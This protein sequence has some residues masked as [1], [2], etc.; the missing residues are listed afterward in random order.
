[1]IKQLATAVFFMVTATVP[2]KAQETYV[3]PEVLAFC[4]E[5]SR[6]AEGIMM[7]R[8]EGIPIEYPMSVLERYPEDLQVLCTN[9][10]LE[11]YGMPIEP[12]QSGKIMVAKAFGIIHRR[13]CMEEMTK[14][15]LGELL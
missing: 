10:I 3:N 8:Q 5:A 15:A 4:E 12:T 9:V 11:A 7:L 13:A 2:L 6:N 14:V 1:M